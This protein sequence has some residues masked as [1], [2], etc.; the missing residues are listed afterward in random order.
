MKKTIIASILSAA[1]ALPIG[2]AIAKGEMKGHPNLIAAQTL[3][4]EAYVKIQAAQKANE[5]DMGGHAKKAEEAL[6]TAVEEIHLA[7]EVANEKK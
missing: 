7:A 2:V 4:K 1:I 6:K 3:I 5:Y